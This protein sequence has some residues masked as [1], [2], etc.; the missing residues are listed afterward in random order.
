MHSC[1]ILLY[2]FFYYFVNFISSSMLNCSYSRKKKKSRPD[3]Y[4][5]LLCSIGN[6]KLQFVRANSLSLS[7]C[8]ILSGAMEKVR[9]LRRLLDIW[10]VKAAAARDKRM[11][12]LATRTNAGRLF[13]MRRSLC[14]SLSPSADLIANLI[15][16][17]EW[18]C[19]SPKLFPAAHSWEQKASRHRYMEH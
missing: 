6:I 3:L 18:N 16:Y 15:Y 13:I 5:D 12:S 9:N 19:S 7:L 8:F 2:T 1:T 17:H 11:S 10:R 14:L 4:N